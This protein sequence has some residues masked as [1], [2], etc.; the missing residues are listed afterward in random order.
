MC[1]CLSPTLPA[2]VSAVLWAGCRAGDLIM[3]CVPQNACRE[4][5]LLLKQ[6]KVQI[7]LPFLCMC[8]LWKRSK[9]L[10][11]NFWEKYP[12]PLV[13]CCHCATRINKESNHI[14]LAEHYH[15]IY[16]HNR[17]EKWLPSTSTCTAVTYSC[18]EAVEATS[19]MEKCYWHRRRVTRT[20]LSINWVQGIVL[21]SQNLNK[22]A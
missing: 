2:L 14:H 11:M 12:V 1:L 15:S 4:A 13:F 6:T 16:A 3:L 22:W 19:E 17:M 10:K 8:M 7:G 5:G 20:K 9:L 21:S 18:P